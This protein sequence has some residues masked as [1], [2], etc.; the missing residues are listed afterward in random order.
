MTVI[1]GVGS[2]NC[3]LDPFGVRREIGVITDGLSNTIMFV[4]Q[5]GRPDYYVLGVKQATNSGLPEPELVGGGASYNSIKYQGYAAN[6]TSSGTA[7]LDHC[8]NSQGV[9]GFHTGGAVFSMCDGSVG[10]SPPAYG[11]HPVPAVQAATAARSPHGHLVSAAGA[12]GAVS[13][14]GGVRRCDG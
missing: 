10:F 13:A 6:G 3:A 5:A 4:E 11:P 9:S 2:A 12:V 14:I 1:T 8:N 7:L